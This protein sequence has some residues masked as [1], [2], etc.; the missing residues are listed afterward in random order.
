[1][2]ERYLTVITEETNLGNKKISI[3]NST[4]VDIVNVSLECEISSVDIK[5]EPDGICEL[6]KNSEILERFIPI[7]YNP[8]DFA[9][10]VVSWEYKD[11]IGVRNHMHCSIQLA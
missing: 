8:C 4:G 2:V 5:I 10:V 9:E 11:N 1:M 3:I 7:T 6:L